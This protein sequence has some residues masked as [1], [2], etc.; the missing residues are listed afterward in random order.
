MF[1]RRVI[2]VNATEH[3]IR[4]DSPPK[5][6]FKKITNNCEYRVIV[7][8]RWLWLLVIDS[9]EG[10]ATPITYEIFSQLYSV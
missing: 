1:L 8:K 5:R 9:V 10:F 3:D 4:E 7:F 6:F 2:T